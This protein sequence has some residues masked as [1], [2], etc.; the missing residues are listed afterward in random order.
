MGSLVVQ[1]EGNLTLVPEEDK[2]VEYESA[3][4]AFSDMLND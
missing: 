2:R 3:D 4:V 1:G